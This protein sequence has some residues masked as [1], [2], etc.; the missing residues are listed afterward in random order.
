[1]V[2][3]FDKNCQVNIAWIGENLKN[4]LSSVDVANRVVDVNYITSIMYR[5]VLEMELSIKTELP[6]ELRTFQEFVRANVDVFGDL[7]KRNILFAEQ[8]MP[9]MIIKALLHHDD[10]ADI[11]NVPA[12]AAN[13]A[14][15]IRNW[16]TS[17]EEKTTIVN[18]LKDSLEKYK[19]EYNFIAL[20]VGFGRLASS[21]WW[22]LQWSRAGMV[23]FGLLLPLPLIAELYYAYQHQA[24]MAKLDTVFLASTAVLSL[25]ITLI[26][27]YFFRI[28]LNSSE[29]CKSYLLQL[30]LRRELCR[31]V[32]EYV[33]YA[34]DIK[35]RSPE[36]LAK[37]ESLIF[38]GIASNNDQSLS[39]FDGI[40]KIGELIKNYKS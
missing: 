28:V 16:D 6:F 31:F 5:F 21:K 3:F 32:Q 20:D 2:D 7:E 33:N 19:I 18:N 9:I 12:A 27:L 25:S 13:V 29:A 35:K 8:Q 40:D 26:F 39:M 36:T 4:R 17:I 11:R 10:M 24:E 15:A 34:E 23:F 38:S 22:E 30:E 1:M 37:F 14:E